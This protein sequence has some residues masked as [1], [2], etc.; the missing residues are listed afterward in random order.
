M[1]SPPARD[2]FKTIH[3]ILALP[4]WVAAALTAYLAVRSSEFQSVSVMVLGLAALVALA[5]LAVLRARR[6]WLILSALVGS[7]V[8]FVGWA[9]MGI[10]FIDHSPTGLTGTVWALQ[11]IANIAALI[12][13][14]IAFVLGI[15]EV[16]RS[17]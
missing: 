16:R 5:G 12:S 7:A 1:T 13:G 8:A 15:I 4:W 10:Q 6:G 17:R 14:L 3:W 9:G 11:N 2:A